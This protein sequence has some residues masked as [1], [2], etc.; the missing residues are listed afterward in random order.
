MVGDSTGRGQLAM[1]VVLPDA[2][3]T[4]KLQP[5]RTCRLQDKDHTK[6]LQKFVGEASLHCVRQ[7]TRS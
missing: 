6:G 7:S 1:C 3:A 4:L 2:R 5:L